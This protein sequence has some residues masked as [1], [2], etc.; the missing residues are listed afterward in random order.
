L[1]LAH[2]INKNPATPA[3]VRPDP[4]AVAGCGGHEVELLFKEPVSARI[5]L[6]GLELWIGMAGELRYV[7]AF[8]TDFL[9]NFEVCCARELHAYLL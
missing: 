7:S 9:F 2:F 5:L 6:L 8:Q 1:F 4:D 3:T